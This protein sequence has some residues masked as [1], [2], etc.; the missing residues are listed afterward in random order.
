[1][2][3]KVI[4]VIPLTKKLAN[5][6]HPKRVL[7]QCGST[8]IIQSQE[9]I[10]SVT[11]KNTKKTAEA[12]SNFLWISLAFSGSLSCLNEYFLEIKRYS[13]HPAMKTAALIKKNGIFKKLVFPWIILSFATTSASIQTNIWLK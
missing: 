10:D 2:V 5:T 12:L 7:Y 8:D 13:N 3:I 6:Y 1:I 9:A 4:T 11:I